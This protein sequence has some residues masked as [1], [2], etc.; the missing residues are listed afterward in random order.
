MTRFK[1]KNQKDIPALPGN[2]G[3]GTF[4]TKCIEKT[5]NENTS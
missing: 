1:K 5:Q 2:Y 3:F 4:E